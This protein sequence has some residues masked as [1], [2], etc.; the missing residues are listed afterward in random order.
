MS[1][2]GNYEVRWTDPTGRGAIYGAKR[3]EFTG[4]D[5][6]IDF[7]IEQKPEV[8][9]TLTILNEGSDDLQ[10]E[11]AKLTPKLCLLDSDYCVPVP[12][13]RQL[14]P[15][16]SGVKPNEWR[17]TLGPI[18]TGVYRV[19]FFGPDSGLPRD[20]YTSSLKQGERDVLR[21]GALVKERSTPV[22]VRLRKGLGTLRGQVVDAQNRPIHDA[23]VVL[24][25]DPPS[26]RVSSLYYRNSTR[27][28]QDGNFSFEKIRPGAYRIYSGFDPASNAVTIKIGE[29]A[30][31]A[32]RIERGVPR[33]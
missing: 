2:P 13:S 12:S 30:N 25:D 7:P 14:I 20:V 4:D 18:P 11:I 26:P 21:E 22:E 27:T 10:S 24:D 17:V 32:I 6:D 3:F 16:G 33:N 31:E 29:G 19:L 5:I 8:Q 9:V 23:R 28:D 1:R 15:L